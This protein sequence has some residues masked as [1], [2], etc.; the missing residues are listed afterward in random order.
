MTDTP[1]LEGAPQ[2]ITRQVLELLNE[3]PEDDTRTVDDV[4]LG[5]IAAALACAITGI[6]V[7]HPGA[8]PLQRRLGLK[9]FEHMTSRAVASLL[10]DENPKEV[11]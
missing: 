9:H 2:K 3:N 1:A 5:L 8:T 10:D 7:A 11:H 6:E 4:L